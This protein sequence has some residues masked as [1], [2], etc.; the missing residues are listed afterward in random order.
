MVKGFTIKKKMM[1]LILGITLSIYTITFGYISITLKEKSVT[2]GQ[3]LANTAAYQKA[4]EI[5]ARLDETMAIS[6]SMANIIKDYVDFPKEQRL[7]MQ[8]DLLVSI[9]KSNPNFE[10]T[11]LS[12]ELDAID[13]SWSKTYGR[14]RSTYFM[15]DGE[16]Q[17]SIQLLNTEGDDLKGVYYWFKTK[18]Q[19]AIS[20][21]YYYEDYDIDSSEKLLGTSPGVPILREGEFLGLIGSDLSLADYEKMTTINI[22]DRGYAFVVSNGG[23]IVAHPNQDLINESLDKLNLIRNGTDF[24]VKILKGELNSFT[25]VDSAAN[26]EVYVAIAPI[27]IGRSETPWAV[28]IAIPTAEITKAFNSTFL[29]TVIVGLL[30]LVVL[31]LVTFRIANSITGSLDRSN[32]LLKDLSRGE[33]DPDKR[34]TISGSD[35]LSEIAASVNTLMYELNRKAEF[36][37]QIGEGNL[38]VDFQPSGENDLL[39]HSLLKMRDNLLAVINETKEVVR[40]AGL[41]GQLSA[42]MVEE[43][44]GGVWGDLSKAINNLLLSVSE[45]VIA[46]NKIVNAMAEGDLT[47]RFEKESQGDILTLSN[48]LNKALDNLIILLSEIAGN[49]N[50]IEESSTEMFVASEEMNLNTGEIASAMSQMSSGAQN[51]VVKVDE[52]SRLVEA[53]LR[54]SGEM[55]EQSETI[56]IAAKKGAEISEEGLK[57]VKKVGFSMSDISAFAED[58]N[59]SFQVLAERSSEITRVLGII[60]DITSQTNLLALN[61]AIEA[62]KAGESGR[63]FAVVAEE[64]RKLAEDSRDSAGEIEKLIR[65]VQVDTHEAAKV[66]EVMN[67]SIKGGEEASRN[68]SVAFEEIALSSS[69]TLNL[70]EGIL[71]ATK[72][73]M[74]DIKNVVSI[75]EGVVVIAEQTAAGTEEVASSASELS[76]GMEN[77][78]QKS[79]RVTEIAA[80]LKKQ[81]EKFRLEREENQLTLK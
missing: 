73:Q 5:K 22:F 30:G 74:E 3:K 7:Q 75:T 47:Y 16:L 10:A 2:E 19:E 32:G 9:L 56:N 61:A 26:E 53:I 21:P 46:V 55:G 28:G 60:T 58:T 67:A 65:D 11:W 51:Q 66:I 34:L 70:S 15:R 37:R 69:Q 6:R 39:G 35:E 25:S 23:T 76:A 49:A 42:R 64:I 45:P 80:R 41:R 68:A 8:E 78:S 44:K 63:G 77:Y 72:N 71:N 4:S 17:S 40:E 59:K 31:G 50:D 62:A 52:S 24:N 12:W 57:M 1:L 18:K 81:V 36:S 13:P 27:A 54:S 14:E 43:G 33:L 79:Q 38:Q 48:N 29:V 20:E